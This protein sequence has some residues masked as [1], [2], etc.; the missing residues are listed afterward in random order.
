VRRVDSL[1]ARVLAGLLPLLLLVIST[2]AF[3]QGTGEQLPDPMG[4]R[5]LSRDLERF[6]SPTVSQWGLIEDLHEAYLERF[7]L[8]RDGDIARFL[9]FTEKEMGAVPDTRTAKEFV[10]RLDAT[11]SKINEED[12]RLFGEI[13]E[14]LDE[15]QLAGLN[16]VRLARER[17]S[18][19]SGFAAQEPGIDLWEILT[20]FEREIG[21]EGFTTI[22]P[23]LIGYEEE[24]TAGLRVWRKAQ[25]SM[26]MV[27]VEELQNR[28][29][30]EMYGNASATS[31]EA[32]K[33]IK[34]FQAA[35][36]SAQ[37]EGLKVRQRIESLDRKAF[38]RIESLLGEG[39]GRRVRM[40]CVGRASEGRIS[41]DPLNV[42]RTIT[43]L[44]EKDE[45]SPDQRDRLQVLRREMHAADDRHVARM[46]ELL[47]ELSDIEDPLKD[48]DI[49][50][51]SE[52]P[53]LEQIWKLRESIDERTGLRAALAESTRSELLRLFEASASPRQI[54]IIESGGRS[55]E[56]ED[57]RPEYTESLSVRDPRRGG[58]S[59][60][61]PDRLTRRDLEGIRSRLALEP[62]QQAILDT[63]HADYVDAWGLEVAP[64]ASQCNTA[65]AAVYSVDPESGR[66]MA[67][68]DQMRRAYAHAHDALQRV[69]RIEDRFFDDLAVALSA[70][71][72]AALRRCRL[73]REL[74][75][76]LC[77][78]DPFFK[79]TE[80][81]FRPA[82]V[83]EVLASQ[84]LTPELWDRLDEYL[85][86][87]AADVIEA[88][89][90]ARGLRF[91]SEQRFHE[92]NIRLST[93]L[94]DGT[95][96]SADHGIEYRRVSDQLAEQYGDQ[97]KEWNRLNEEFRE[98]IRRELDPPLQSA[99]DADWNRA[100]NP[101]VY[102]D[103]NAAFGSIEQALR[104]P[105]LTSDQLDAIAKLLDEYDRAWNEL[106]SR[107]SSMHAEKKRF[108]ANTNANEE[109]FDEW[110]ALDQRY[111]ASKFERNEASLRA[112]RRLS[113][114][115]Q[116]DQRLKIR[117]LRRID[118]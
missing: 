104:L 39:V 33:A 12:A 72:A 95:M 105:D 49:V 92:M 78:T 21:P 56:L 103:P 117:G 94:A 9:E 36:E 32:Q 25:A 81:A 52:D 96:S 65:L 7:A 59:D 44:L 64:I 46:I 99:F 10:R 73:E 53:V 75:R 67:D 97:V 58:P 112:L 98:G 63:I 101:L 22:D 13:A 43:R 87:S 90:I 35:Y 62:W 1:H 74:D 40:A 5:V 51:D 4:S 48:F 109:A 37:L 47:R 29:L 66:R 93:G 80:L 100:A 110:R 84:D 34:A 118:P 28:G 91:N 17:E 3:A 20:S 26:F 38:E 108:G 69:V 2:T 71:Q 19:K 107:M 42:D 61:I 31:E 83:L 14:I 85:D 115:L 11:R 54:A 76:Q 116:P 57:N 68:I 79:P 18:L 102:R 6:V 60:F 114:Y 41:R 111:R 88:A 113:R 86:A 15:G 24:L 77:G 30:G 27:L 16:R 82:N 50:I 70:S 23:V 89:S 45:L 55:P 8:L 106:S